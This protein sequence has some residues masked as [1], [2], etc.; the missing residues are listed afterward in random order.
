M[1]RTASDAHRDADIAGRCCEEGRPL[2]LSKRLRLGRLAMDECTLR[3]LLAA[4]EAGEH[5][6]CAAV[7]RKVI[8]E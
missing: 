3:A 2:E 7:M 8:G 5:H 1:F 6:D 4:A